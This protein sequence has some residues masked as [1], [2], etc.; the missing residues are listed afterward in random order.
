MDLPQHIP[1]ES[2]PGEGVPAAVVEAATGG[3]GEPV[4]AAGVDR[5]A[6]FG[7]LDTLP[8]VEYD[9]LVSLAAH[10]CGAPMAAVSFL[11]PDRQWFKARLG[12]TMQE[13]PRDQS[14]CAVAMEQP[15][16]VLLVPDARR[17]ARFRDNPL[18]LGAGG[19]RFYAGAPLVTADG[20]AL[21][22]LCVLDTVPR[23]L[24]AAQ[25]AALRALAVQCSA[26]L[27][28]RRQAAD[29]TLAVAERDAAQDRALVA[30]EQL[31]SFF[32][33]NTDAMLLSD[34]NGVLL[35]VNAAGAGLTGRPVE[36]LVGETL[37]GLTHHADRHVAKAS[38][39]RVGT[40]ECDV[41]VTE[42]RLV[43]GPGDSLNVPV[44]ATTRLIRGAH[45][46]PRSLICQ[47]EPT[48]AASA[49]AALRR[50]LTPDDTARAVVDDSGTVLAW[51]LHA[52]RLLDWQP[53]EVLGRGVGKV[54]VGLPPPP[55]PG[56]STA[57]ADTGPRSP[58]PAVRLLAQ[59]PDGSSVPVDVVVTPWPGPGART[60]RVEL[61][62]ASA[63][64]EAP[65][66][67]VRRLELAA[68]SAR[69]ALVAN[70][71]LSL[72]ETARLVG[73]DLLA[74]GGWDAVRILLTRDAGAE[75]PW[76][77][78]WSHAPGAEAAERLPSRDGAVLLARVVGAG[79]ALIEPDDFAAV[80]VRVGAGIGGIL[81]LEVGAG[82][83]LAEDVV[84]MLHAVIAQMG[85]GEAAGR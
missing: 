61:R 76:T 28:S 80:P 33:H 14:F 63:L 51:N 85:R 7:I 23:T 6:S 57:A 70:R 3:P 17:D 81:H 72:G 71:G 47:L 4:R 16:E 79:K 21:G 9:A 75:L 83:A 35:Q 18:V 22:A 60:R 41:D 31:T 15:E 46:T 78:G 27:A 25:E 45:G 82:E 34:L 38:L 32:T 64:T 43:S 73:C 11:T 44:I 77:S 54:L 50:E 62:P 59:R 66:S 58:G 30:G 67:S 48:A 26:L 36:Q 13:T 39:A 84:A 10:I 68:L 20:T 19:V 65:S 24:S 12:L 49:P 29:L 5:L 2:D 8:E 40:G 69:A 1:T 37:T 55:S 52:V 56:D 42:L 53:G 74:W